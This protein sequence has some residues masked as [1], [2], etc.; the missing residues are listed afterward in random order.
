M[1]W[2]QNSGNRYYKFHKL[3]ARLVEQHVFSDIGLCKELGRRRHEELSCESARAN[4]L[5]A[6]VKGTVNIDRETARGEQR[7]CQ[8]WKER[9]GDGGEGTRLPEKGPTTGSI[10]GAIIGVIILLAIIGT[11]IAM[12][13]KHRHNKLNGDGPPKYKPPPPKKTKSSTNRLLNTNPAPVAEDRPLQ[14]Q[15]YTTQ[16][17][18]PV[19]AHHVYDHDEHVWLYAVGLVGPLQGRSQGRPAPSIPC[20]I[21]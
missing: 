6:S 1:E 19:T 11:G 12:Y 16:S 3:S 9:E 21:G 14:N 20:V 18:E 17:V 8:R 2:C 7:P 10:I 4:H 15:H 5:S 13:R